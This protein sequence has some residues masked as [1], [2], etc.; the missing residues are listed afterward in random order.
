MRIGPV[1]F[2]PAPWPTA[3]AAALVALT[4]FLGRW[5]VSRAHE[6]EAL[7]ELYEARG[8]EAP[9]VLAGF[10]DAP[11]PLLYRHVRA[12]GEYEPARQL[13]V[14]NQVMGGAA[15]YYVVTPL[16]LRD[17]SVLLVNRG[18][19]ARG[20]RYPEPPPA[21]VPAGTMQVSGIATLPPRRFLELGPHVITGSVWQNL[22][23]D[24]Y[25][26]A[27]GERVLP[28]IV[29]A[30]AAGAGLAAVR[31]RPDTGIARHQE[32]ALTWFS[33]AATTLVLW[34]VLNV[35]RTP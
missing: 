34:I 5:Q 31:E 24:R 8:R 17:G 23:I 27:S 13:Y 20:P 9:L 15:G 11:E 22:S 32:Y 19:I 25:R 6:K 30:D 26:A 33:L 16:K 7:Q 35:R 21:A 3:A 4:I 14:D 10:V 29:V 18:W 2:K 12:S 1:A 28:V